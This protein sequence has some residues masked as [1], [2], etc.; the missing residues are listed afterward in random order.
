MRLFPY[1]G[2]FI[3]YV[4]KAN[5]FHLRIKPEDARRSVLRRLPRLKGWKK[6][7][8]LID[9]RAIPDVMP[10]SHT[11]TDVRNKFLTN[12]NEGNAERLVEHVVPLRTS[13]RHLLYVCGLTTTCFHPELSYSIKDSNDHGNK[14]DWILLFVG[15]TLRVLSYPCFVFFFCRAFHRYF[16]HLLV[17]TGTVVSKGDPIPNDQCPVNRTTPPLVIGQLIPEKTVAQRNVEK[18]NTKIAKAS[19]K[20]K[21][22]QAKIHLKHAGEEGSVAPQKKRARKARDA[23]ASG[24]EETTSVTSIHQAGLKPINETTISQENVDLFDAHS[25]HSDHDEGNDEDATAHRVSYLAT[26]AKDEFLSGLSNVEVVRRAYQ[27]LGRGVL[28][29]GDLLKR[30]EQLNGDYFDLYNHNDTQLEELNYLRNDLQRG[31]KTSD[32]MLKKLVDVR[33]S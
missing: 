22:A 14:Y 29:Q 21:L 6:K 3:S 33:S 31:M 8:F 9:R 11:D 16:L 28:V 25:F 12:Y 10:W 24:S 15:I 7:F 19:E 23:T 17:W 2:D 30:H 5:G 32:G 20:E 26:P 4:N 18:P 1:S 13:P 27:L